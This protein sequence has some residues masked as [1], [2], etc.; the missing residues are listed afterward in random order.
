MK[1]KKC[2][3]VPPELLYIPTQI[4]DGKS[5]IALPAFKVDTTPVVIYLT[6]EGINYAKKVGYTVS[7][8]EEH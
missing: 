7:S 2:T 3:L 5:I 1:F 8:I 6:N 4:T